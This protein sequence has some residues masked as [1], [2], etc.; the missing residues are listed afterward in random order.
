MKDAENVDLVLDELRKILSELKRLEDKDDY[1]LVNF[2]RDSLEFMTDE[3]L[4]SYNL[5]KELLSSHLREEE[6]LVSQA[7]VH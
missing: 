5:V 2:Y 4:K 1:S 7:E 6:A 3:A